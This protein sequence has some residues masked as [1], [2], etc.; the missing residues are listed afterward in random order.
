MYILFL[1]TSIFLLL[2]LFSYPFIVKKYK[3]PLKLSDNNLAFYISFNPNNK[4]NIKGK[5]SV[6]R[7]ISYIIEFN[8]TL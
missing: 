5:L 2:Y 4:K 7:P 8:I 1:I 3:S 6:C